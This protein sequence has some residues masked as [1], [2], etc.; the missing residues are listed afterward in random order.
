MDKIK[1]RLVWQSYRFDTISAFLVGFNGYF[2]GSF[3]VVS[4]LCRKTGL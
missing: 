3:G 2:F 1:E 4:Q